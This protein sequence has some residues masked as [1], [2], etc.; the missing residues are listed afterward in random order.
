LL[1][2]ADYEA[3]LTELEWALKKEPADPYWQLY[4]LTSLHR[5]GRTVDH[6]G[7]DDATANDWPGPLL[8]LHAGRLSAEDA[9]KRADNEG[10]R[11]EALFQVAVVTYPSDRAAAC[12][13]W[14][15]VI[16][17]APPTMIEHAAAR[18]ELA[19]LGS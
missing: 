15:Q 11:A 8:A 18:H 13:H 3:A 7:L 12:R 5:L 4:R 14:Q 10:R 9:L 2:L 1:R 16:E 6:P 17:K 19:R